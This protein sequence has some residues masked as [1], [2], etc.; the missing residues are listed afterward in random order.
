MLMSANDG[1]AVGVVGVARLFV[2]HNLTEA[3]ALIGVLSLSLAIGNML[4]FAP[5]DGG[6]MFMRLLRIWRVPP[7]V[8]TAIEWVGTLLVAG[9]FVLSEMTDVLF[10]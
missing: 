4:P 7:R 6:Q 8:R 5:L 1:V 10:W 9:I 2:A 3:V